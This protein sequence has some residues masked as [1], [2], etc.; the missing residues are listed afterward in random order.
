MNNECVIRKAEYE[1]IPVI[2]AFI[3]N[4][5]KKGHILARSRKYFEYQHY[6]N[7]EVSFVLAEEPISK[8]IEGILGYILYSEEEKRDMFGVIWKVRTNNYPMLGMKIQLYAM[9]NLN[10]RTFSG[11]GLNQTTIEMHKR[12]GAMVGKLKQYYILSDRGDYSIAKV[13]SLDRNK[14]NLS[15][16]QF[17]LR[18]MTGDEGLQIVCEGE[19]NSGKMPV[20]SYNF[21]KHRYFE[22]P[23]YNYLKYSIY[24]KENILG[25]FISREIECNGSKIL[26]I[27]DYFGDES[28]IRHTGRALENLLQKEGY[29]YIDFYQY[30]IDKDILVDAGFCERNEEDKNII[31]NYFEP[32]LQENVDLDFYTTSKGKV[33][34]FKADG[35]QDRPNVISE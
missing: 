17:E 28:Y 11:V 4:Y 6:Y 27:V 20:K 26:R 19:K 22:N 13:E 10:A 25:I 30:G 8:E 32:F 9:R 12:W 2:M 24:D 5:W 14:Y 35:D 21:I 33:M 15:V 18:P 31:P 16:E 7:G 29:E 34:L 3:D 23:V 1:D